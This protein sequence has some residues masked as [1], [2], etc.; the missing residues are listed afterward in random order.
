MAQNDAQFKYEYGSGIVTIP[1]TDYDLRVGYTQIDLTVQQMS[2]NEMTCEAVYID[3]R[4]AQQPVIFEN[5]STGQVLFV[6]PAFN[7]W[8]IFFAKAPINFRIYSEVA[9]VISFVIANKPLMSDFNVPANTQVAAIAS[10]ANGYTAIIPAVAGSYIRLSALHVRHT[11]QTAGAAA[12]TTFRVQ[13]NT[14][15]SFGFGGFFQANAPVD[16][17]L[18]DMENLNVITNLPGESVGI[19]LSQAITGTGYLNINLSYSYVR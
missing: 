5:Q 3:T 17:S 7:G 19:F 16:R 12:N 9:Q 6:P 14:F 4:K 18:L 1:Y 10:N 2:G 11:Q 15:K 8:K 13:S